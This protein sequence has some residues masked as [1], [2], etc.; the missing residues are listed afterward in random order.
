MNGSAIFRKL[1][2]SAFLLIAAIL[3]PLDIYITRIQSGLETASIPPPAAADE[4]HAKLLE[5]G[6]LA[7]VAALALAYLASRSLTRRVARLRAFADGCVGADSAPAPISETM[8]DEV[9]SLALAVNRMAGRLGAMRYMGGTH[10]RR[11]MS[12]DRRG[13][14]CER[15]RR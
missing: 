14:A 11:F 5:F 2:L 13:N 10:A 8:D 3:V 12:D 1:V 9:A 7:A 4:V 6:L 15:L